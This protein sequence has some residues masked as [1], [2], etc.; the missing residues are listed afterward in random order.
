VLVYAVVDG[1]SCKTIWALCATLFFKEDK[2]MKANPRTI[3][4]ILELVTAVAVAASGVIVK[5]YIDVPRS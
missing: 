3:I 2:P 4:M 5:Y 1:S